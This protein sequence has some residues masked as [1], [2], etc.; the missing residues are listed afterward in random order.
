M[1]ATHLTPQGTRDSLTH[2]TVRARWK[3]T[4]RQIPTG[5]ASGGGCYLN[6]PAYPT[7]ISQFDPQAMRVEPQMRTDLIQ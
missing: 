6:E 7:R 4:L 1:A 5:R 3:S 2:T